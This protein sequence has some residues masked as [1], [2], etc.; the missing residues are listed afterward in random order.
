MIIVNYLI[1][2]PKA[3]LW[4]LIG[5]VAVGLFAPAITGLLG[6]VV[7]H[8][9]LLLLGVGMFLGWRIASRGKADQ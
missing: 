1:A 2:N 6:L 5:V 7:E 4:V 3:L 8:P 9:S